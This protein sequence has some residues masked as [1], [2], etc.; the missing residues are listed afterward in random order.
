MAVRPGVVSSVSVS[1]RGQSV[2]L[3]SGYSAPVRAPFPLFPHSVSKEK[4]MLLIVTEGRKQMSV[5]SPDGML[6]S[7]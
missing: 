3:G 7:H 6:C 4:L 2:A 5:F 1:C